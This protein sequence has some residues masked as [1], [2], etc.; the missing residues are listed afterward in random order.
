MSRDDRFKKRLMARLEELDARL[1]HI[2]GELDKPRTEDFA[3]H[4]TESEADEVLEHLGMAGL[5]EIDAI[6]VALER[7]QSGT[8]GICAVCGEKISDQRLEVVPYTAT[9]RNCAK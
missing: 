9:C 6:R 7:I 1:H 4:A 5:N 8:F 3:D 2:E